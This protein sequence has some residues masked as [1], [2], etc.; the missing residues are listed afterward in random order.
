MVESYIKY[1]FML[2]CSLYIF[3]KLI[4]VKH[5]KAR[6]IVEVVLCPV[7]GSIIYIV[8]MEFSH[9]TTFM[10]FA[11]V[12]VYTMI[13]YNVSTKI[14]ITASL[15]SVALSY[16][17]FGVALSLTSIIL[18]AVLYK[19]TNNEYNFVY[20]MSVVGGVQLFLCY[21]VFC[22]KRFK[23]GMPFLMEKLSNTLGVS[24]GCTI[25][26][27]SSF[28]TVLDKGN[29]IKY[30]IFL[31]CATLGLAFFIWW[32]KQF[33]I[34]YIIRSNKNEIS[35]LE[36]E[37]EKLKNDNERLAELIHKDN[38]LIPAMEMCVR[39][40]LNEEAE[41]EN[42]HLKDTATRLM[43]ELNVLSN[44]RKGILN[45]DLKNKKVFMETGHIR[46]D[47]TINYMLERAEA[48]KVELEVNIGTDVSKMIK[49]VVSEEILVT[50]IADMLENA[51]IACKN[52]EDKNIQLVIGK[53][54]NH[55]YVSVYDS[56]IPF[57]PYTIVNAGKTK[58]STH[59]DDGGSGIGLMTI[60]AFLRENLASFLIDETV[61]EVINIDGKK[62]TKKVM[63]IF[64]YKNEYAINSYRQEIIDLKKENPRILINA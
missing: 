53:E 63:V 43:E 24:I 33:N 18:G 4:D 1:V 44:E 64:D 36:L 54:D 9:M 10:L 49:N 34:S 25:V 60:F 30:Y 57:E 62:Y 7:L 32:K 3:S 21:I 27:L 37:I 16:I 46:L 13:T 42:K 20:I 50:M 31:F 12:V 45:A 35:R 19:V 23:R 41:G 8:R 15:I 5:T 22:L 28:F 51:I 52:V 2:I 58:A 38:K 6:R 40:M 59:I 48:D 56:G 26:F 11:V 47:A 39:R 29:E 17:I 14:M 61:D 55:Y